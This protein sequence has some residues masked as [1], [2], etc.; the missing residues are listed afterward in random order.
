MTS[1][2]FQGKNCAIRERT[3]DGVSV[4]RCFFHLSETD[5]CPRHGD[6]KSE[7]ERFRETGELQE[8][9]RR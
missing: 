1:E 9:P 5:T 8:D 3:A 7:M 4:D 2:V 6:V